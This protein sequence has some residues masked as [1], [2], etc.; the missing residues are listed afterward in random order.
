MP[1]IVVL[2]PQQ[3][4]D[5][6]VRCAHVEPRA[7]A[8]VTERGAEAVREPL[9]QPAFDAGRGSDD[10]LAGEHV[11]RCLGEQLRELVGEGRG[12]VTTMQDEGHVA[13]LTRASDN[14]AV[15]R[16]TSARTVW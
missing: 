15:A 10:E 7:D 12:I 16:K 8:V 11:E 2:P 9:R 5:E 6:G 1:R 3:E 4:R 14:R 13:K